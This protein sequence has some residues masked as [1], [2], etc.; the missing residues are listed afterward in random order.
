M[1][2]LLGGGGRRKMRVRRETTLHVLTSPPPLP[3]LSA[4]FQV[5]CELFLGQKKVGN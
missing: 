3:P 4:P 1:L 2:S 5:I